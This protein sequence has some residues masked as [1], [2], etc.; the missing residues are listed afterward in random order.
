MLAYGVAY[1]LN[2][3]SFRESWK[4][5]FLTADMLQESAGWQWT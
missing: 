2:A 5:G 4:I 3:L 1:G